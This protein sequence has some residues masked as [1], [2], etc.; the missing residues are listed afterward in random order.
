LQYKKIWNEK[1][2]CVAFA[3][4]VNVV[5]FSQDR[6]TGHDLPQDLSNCMQ[7]DGCNQPALAT[8]AALDV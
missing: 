5:A 4:L 1:N 8:Q 6:I 3:I 2:C 7:W